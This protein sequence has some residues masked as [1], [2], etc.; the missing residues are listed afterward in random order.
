LVSESSEFDF[1]VREEAIV[2]QTLALIDAQPQEKEFA[3]FV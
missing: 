2:L 1:D 3:L